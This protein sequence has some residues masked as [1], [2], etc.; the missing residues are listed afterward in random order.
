MSRRSHGSTPARRVGHRQRPR[1]RCQTLVGSQEHDV[2]IGEFP[3]AQCDLGQRQ[4][5]RLEEHTVVAVQSD[6]VARPRSTSRSARTAGGGRRRFQGDR[7]RRRTRPTS[8]RRRREQVSVT[9]ISEPSIDSIVSADSHI[10]CS[11]ASVP[12]PSNQRSTASRRARIPDRPANRSRPQCETRIVVSPPV[13][14]VA[15]RHRRSVR[16]QPRRTLDHRADSTA[17]SESRPS[18]TCRR[19]RRRR[20]AAAGKLIQHLEDDIDGWWVS[21]A[22]LGTTIEIRIY[23]VATAWLDAGLEHLHDSPRTRRR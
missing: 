4:F 3:R 9:G 17:C 6:D 18:T 12:S 1:A 7:R 8:T 23:D 2:R 19:R 20:R 13:Q 10:S 22:Q 11:A 5:G 14:V 15:D 21:V 16:W